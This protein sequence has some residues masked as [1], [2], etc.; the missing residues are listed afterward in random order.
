[1]TRRKA[2]TISASKRGQVLRLP[3]AVA[4]PDDVRRVEILKLGRSRLIVPAGE[5]WDDFFL[6]GPH[7]TEDFFS[8]QP[9]ET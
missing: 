1:M 4:F 6:N 9:D 8:D 3:K 2:S 5:R 7:A